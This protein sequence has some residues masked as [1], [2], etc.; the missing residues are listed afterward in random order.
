MGEGGRDDGGDDKGDDNG[1]DDGDVYMG[2]SDAE[3]KVPDLS[4]YYERLSESGNGG[5]V[6]SS[7]AVDDLTEEE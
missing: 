3:D 1:D 6:G 2:D 7:A 4:D 5:L